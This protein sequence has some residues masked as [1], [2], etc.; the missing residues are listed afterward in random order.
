MKRAG[1]YKREKRLYLNPKSKTT[2]GLWLDTSPLIILDE[3]EPPPIKGK[4]VRELLRR[5]RE[6]VPQPTDW[7]N[8]MRAFLQEVGV[9]S[10]SR[11][12]KTAVTCTIEFDGDQF[13]FRPYRRGG[14]KDHYA[15]FPIEDRKMTI[16][17][18]ASDEELGLML[19]KAFNACE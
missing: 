9:K 10:W 3:T 17:S 8:L 14:P 15:F 16:S 13:V 12:A 2:M 5:S 18:D 7:D 19:E 4:Q 11:F 1:A 6:G